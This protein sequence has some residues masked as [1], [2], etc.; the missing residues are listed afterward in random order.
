MTDNAS[1]QLDRLVVSLN[2]D[3]LEL[4]APSTLASA[5]ANSV[6]AGKPLAAAVNGCFIPRNTYPQYWLND[7]DRIDL[8]RPVGGG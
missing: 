5:I 1:P 3:R 8:V 2:G 4:P 7:G 6:M